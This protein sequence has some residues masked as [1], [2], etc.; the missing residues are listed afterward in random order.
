MKN[1]GDPQRHG[2]GIVHNE[3]VSEGRDKPK[4]YGKR[5]QVFANRTDQWP[6]RE[7][8]TCGV[9]RFFHSVRRLNTVLGYVTPDFKKVVS[10]L[11]CKRVAGHA[12]RWSASHDVFL[13]SINRRTESES[14]NSPRSAAAYPSSIFAPI[15]ERR[16]ASHTS[17]SCNRETA[18]ST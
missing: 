5:R 1:A 7:H 8:L 16:S 13:S 11:R 9:N 18:R 12:L 2:L 17:C 14:S 4:A 3:V 15:S 6:A 10:S